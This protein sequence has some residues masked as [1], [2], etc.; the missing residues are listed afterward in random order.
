MTT[1]AGAL[2]L[3]EDWKLVDSDLLA[4]KEPQIDKA[5]DAEA[6]FWNV[7]VEDE[8]NENYIR[9]VRRHYRR[10]KIFTDK[11]REDQGQVDLLF[12]GRM[13]ISDVAGRT[14]RPDGQ[15]LELKKDDIHERVVRKRRGREVSA[16]SFAL[17]GV[18]PG[19]VIEY[20]WKE[21]YYDQLTWYVSLPLQLEIPVWQIKYSVKPYANEWFP[22]PMRSNA[23]NVKPP[24][25]TKEEGGYYGATFE[26]MPAFRE[27]PYMPPE[28]EVK[29]WMLLYYSP[30]RDPTVDGYWRDYGRE[31]FK[32]FKD[33][34]KP[35]GELTAAAQKI[36]EG[37]TSTADKCA[38]LVEFCRTKIK[39]VSDDA[40]RADEKEEKS[41]QKSRSPK[42]TLQRGVGTSGRIDMLFAALA[43]SAGLDVHI[44]M[45]PDRS[46]I[47]FDPKLP[48]AAFLDR[49][50]VAVRDGETWRLYE[51]SSRYA[52]VGMLRWQNEGFP[53]LVTDAKQPVFTDS[54]LSGPKLSVSHRTA[55]L[56]LSD[57]GAL[58]GSVRLEYT[59]HAAAERKERYDDMSQQRREEAVRDLVKEHLPSA[60][61]TNVEMENVTDPERPLIVA[62]HVK[63]PDYATR[64]G[65]R[66]FVQ[67][68]FFQKGKAALFPAQE[69]RL[70]VCF[71]YP[72]SEQDEIRL[73]LPAGFALEEPVA[74]AP[75]SA[76]P[77]AVYGVKMF[78]EDQGHVLRYERRLDF[79][80]QGRI[81][82]APAHY[83]G[84]KQLFDFIYEG[85][86]HTLSLKPVEQA[87]AAPAR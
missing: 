81:H 9:A 76:P 67:P 84:V 57:E 39:N 54:P 7:R 62:Y 80:D 4:L 46:N 31:M 87:S 23:F 24:T 77:V 58:E 51:P 48:Q 78:L 5:A 82:F 34:L 55:G 53:V 71:D 12:S 29:A 47:F 44:A 22:Y 18:V 14:I 21:T 52:P 38:R 72:W 59:G 25:W 60:E 73:E 45:A 11:G 83:K 8:A 40:V 1:L 79:G 13:G 37:A 66:F 50:L 41:A 63:V 70:A 27:E 69:R 64:T 2:A 86:G 30:D 20:R 61:V 17:P 3:A 16:K 33:D 65:K 15:I 75:L 43:A 35:N 26:K 10:V 36:V 19:A 68:A 85:D 32:I 56:K 42:D 28:N 74:P 49:Y 6:V